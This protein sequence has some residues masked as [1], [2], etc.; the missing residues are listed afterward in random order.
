MV[1][2]INENMKETNDTLTQPNRS[3]DARNEELRV[4]QL[5]DDEIAR[6]WGILCKTRST[7]PLPLVIPPEHSYEDQC[8]IYRRFNE[9]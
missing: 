5:S 7:E 4:P 1:R 6:R 9:T 2:N 8:E 3:M